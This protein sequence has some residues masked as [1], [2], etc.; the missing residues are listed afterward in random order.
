MPIW[1]NFYRFA[2]LKAVISNMMHQI[3]ENNGQLSAH[4][5][6][7]L[8]NQIR[9]LTRFFCYGVISMNFCKHD[10]GCLQNH[11]LYSNNVVILGENHL[12][13]FNFI[14]NFFK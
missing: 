2:C 9:I 6:I 11:I 4:W 1:L 13:T 5:S 3:L 14:K 7:N 10:S 8:N 12:K